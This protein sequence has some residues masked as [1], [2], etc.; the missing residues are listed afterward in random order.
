[1]ME[2][3]CVQG[4]TQQPRNIEHIELTDQPGSPR[5]CRTCTFWSKCHCK[6]DG[7]PNCRAK[8]GCGLAFS[9]AFMGGNSPYWLWNWEYLCVVADDSE[10]TVSNLPSFQPTLTHLTFTIESYTLI[11]RATSNLFPQNS[12]SMCLSMAIEPSGLR[13]TTVESYKPNCGK[14]SDS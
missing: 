5:S 6:H 12:I 3:S 9:P 1:M 7:A 10:T 11:L 13:L 14:A 4:W 2:I 8:G